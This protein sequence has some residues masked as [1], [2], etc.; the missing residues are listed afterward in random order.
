MKKIIVVVFL[1]YAKYVCGAKWLSFQKVFKDED[2]KKEFIYDFYPFIIH[3]LMWS[4]NKIGAEDFM[5][6]F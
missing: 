4:F 1:L 5:N 2:S 6:N 3:R